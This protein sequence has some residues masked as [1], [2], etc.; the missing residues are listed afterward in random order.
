MKINKEKIVSKV[1]RIVPY[2]FIVYIAFASLVFFFIPK[3]NDPALIF[4]VCFGWGLML[5][6]SLFGY[7][8][9]IKRT[10]LLEEMRR[11]SKRL[12]L[13]FERSREQLQRIS[14]LRY[15]LSRTVKENEVN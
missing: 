9:D 4:I 13:V 2:V 6:R 15:K 7:I 14:L 11:L 1:L 5:A 3:G 8:E 12:D 10:S